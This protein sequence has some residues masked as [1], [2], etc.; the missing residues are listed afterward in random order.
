[1]VAI[2]YFWGRSGD[3]YEETRWLAQLLPHRH[4]LPPDLHLACLL[5]FHRAAS[6][7]QEF[8]SID[9]WTEE[10]RALLAV[11][12]DKLLQAFAWSL[13]AGTMADFDQAAAARE[14]SIALA[15]A[16]GEHPTPDLAYGAISD[17]NFVLSAYLQWYAVFLIEQGELARAAPL[18]AEGLALARTQGDP[19]GISDGC[20]IVGRL[21]LLSDLGQA[22][23]C[24]QEAVTIAAT[25]H[26][27]QALC[28]W[29]PFLGIVTL[30]GGDASEAR[31]LLNESLQL[32]LQQKDTVHLA[33]IYTFLAEVEL[34]EDA[35]DAAGR[36]LAQSLA[37]SLADG[38][39]PTRVTVDHVQR[40]WVAA[41]LATA[42]QQYH[43]AATLFGLADHAHREIHHAI[44]GPMRA[45][46]DAA[47]VTVQDA[48]EPAHFVAAFAAGHQLSTA[49]ALAAL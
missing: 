27:R 40:C 2:S 9:P 43:L 47:L 8:P 19:W 24:F 42:R 46:A 11:C 21:A 1:M 15:R 20:G 6:T 3:A 23:G 29:Q 45:L 38:A 5:T 22:Q 17:Q 37:Q 7:M 10:V 26:I 49:E 41:R 31:R 39:R 18:A 34:R 36:W 28:T 4:A 44:G 12:E 48:L 25:F 32:C 13:L 35:A 16:A 14:R 33:Q 30:Y